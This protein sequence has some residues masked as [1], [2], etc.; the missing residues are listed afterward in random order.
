[1][2]QLNCVLL[3]PRNE[4]YEAAGFVA[5][6]SDTLPTQT[7]LGT[8]ATVDSNGLLQSMTLA[9]DGERVR[10]SVVAVREDFGVYQTNAR[11]SSGAYLIDPNAKSFRSI[12]SDQTQVRLVRGPLF[13]ESHVVVDGDVHLT[14][15]MRVYH[16][17]PSFIDVMHRVK[18]MVCL[19][20]ERVSFLNE[21]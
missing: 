19:V 14:R 1:M 15:A 16:H 9:P 8:A 6:R 17:D 3:V 2:F 7:P 5:K 20:V 21:F 13:D 10:A 11:G 12:V 18:L 4:E